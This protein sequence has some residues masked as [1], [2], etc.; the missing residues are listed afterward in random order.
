[1]VERSISR[2]IIHPSFRPSSLSNNIALLNMSSP[3]TFNNYIR[4][5]CL[6]E[7]GS[8]YEEGYTWVTGYGDTDTYSRK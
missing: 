7:S 5:V 1:M 4:P 6:A 3:V 8:V 2:V